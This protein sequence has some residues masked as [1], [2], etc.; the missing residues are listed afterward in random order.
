MTKEDFNNLD[1][2]SSTNGPEIS[3]NSPL[4]IFYKRKTNQKVLYT[5][6]QNGTFNVFE[7]DDYQRMHRDRDF[8]LMYVLKGKL[9]NYLEDRVF[10]FYA[11]EGC[12]L[13][14]Q[15][16]HT[17]KLQDNCSVVFINLSETLLKQLLSGIDTSGFVFSFLQN[18]LEDK[19]SWQRNYL[20]FNT[21]VN[22]SDKA[23][24]II[25]D[26]LQQEITT[27]KIGSNYLQQGLILR[28]LSEL[29]DTHHFQV[30]TNLL[31][32]SKKD[33]LVNQ[34]LQLIENN[35]GNISRKVLEEELHYN[36]EYLNRILKEKTNKTLTSYSQEVRVHKAQE[37]LTT[38]GL[39][40]QMIAEKLGFSSENYFYH[41]FKKHVQLSPNVKC[42]I[43]VRQEI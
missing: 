16:K 22:N 4:S 28:L 12:L 8:E 41:Y 26:S 27:V 36:A 37:L 35:T 18:N 2:P 1:T 10:S 33:Y 31:D 24:R 7:A 34:I 11:G 21:Q 17:E 9:T 42:F 43:I 19:N 3:T 32:Y 15:M 40:V 38:T 20:K 23:F 39:T 14:P 25:L 5:M 13:N 29:Q 6:I 30:N